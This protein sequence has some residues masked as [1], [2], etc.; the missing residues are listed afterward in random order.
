MIRYSRV[1]ITD[2]SLCLRFC[3]CLSV[4]LSVSLS[5]SLSHTHTLLDHLNEVI[6][7]AKAK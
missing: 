5:L 3:L 6:I 4:C 7:D 2:P 1:M